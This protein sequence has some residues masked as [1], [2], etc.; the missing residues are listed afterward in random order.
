MDRK[1]ISVFRD[2]ELCII[3]VTLNGKKYGKVLGEYL[4][5]FEYAYHVFNSI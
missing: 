3:S 1:E 5:S 2:S 4:L